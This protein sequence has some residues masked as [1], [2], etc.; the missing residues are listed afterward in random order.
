VI[1]DLAQDKVVGEIADTPGVHAF[2]RVFKQR[3]RIERERSRSQN[4]EDDR[5]SRIGPEPGHHPV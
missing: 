4:L 1:V 5:E 3:D 2:A